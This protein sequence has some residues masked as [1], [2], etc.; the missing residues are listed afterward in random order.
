MYG[1]KYKKKKKKRLVD[2]ARN[3]ENFAVSLILPMSLI[4]Q[5]IQA[6]FGKF[7]RNFLFG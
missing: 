1:W 4:Y 2:K 5:C 6:K 3:D 7:G